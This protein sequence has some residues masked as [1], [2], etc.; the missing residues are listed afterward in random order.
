MATQTIDVSAKINNTRVYGT[1]IWHEASCAATKG[2][3]PTYE[4]GTEQCDD[5]G[6]SDFSV[7]QHHSQSAS[8]AGHTLKCRHCGALYPL[9]S[10]E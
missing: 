9:R 10:E 6:A 5:C 3:I 2:V 8:S 1:L 7:A 4:G